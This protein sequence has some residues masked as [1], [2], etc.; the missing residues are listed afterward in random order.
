MGRKRKPQKRIFSDNGWL[1]Y[2]SMCGGYKPEEEFNKDK[3]R[4]FGLYY[5][6]KEHRTQ[7][8]REKNPPMEDMDYIKMVFVSDEDHRQ[9]ELLL[10]Q[11]GYDLNK[12]VH[13]QF[14][15][16]I[17]EKYGKILQ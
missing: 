11:L 13:K 2:C 12:E 9:K 14:L 15:Q 6:C 1:Y 7:Q 4:P 3:N 16:R 8:Y 5:I 17:E 10:K